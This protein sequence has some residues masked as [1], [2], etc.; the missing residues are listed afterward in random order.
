MTNSSIKPTTAAQAIILKAVHDF[1]NPPKVNL[2]EQVVEAELN[3]VEAENRLNKLKAEIQPQIDA[4]AKRADRRTALEQQA[5]RELAEDGQISS[6]TSVALDALDKSDKQASIQR[7][8]DDAAIDAANQNLKLQQ[9]I[10]KRE[11]LRFYLH[12]KDGPAQKA[13]AELR[14]L[15][16]VLLYSFLNIF[17]IFNHARTKLGWDASNQPLPAWFGPAGVL[18]DQLQNIR[19]VEWPAQIRPS[20][21]A[22]NGK[23]PTAEKLLRD[24]VAML[25]D[26]EREKEAA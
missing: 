23:R 17:R 2:P 3:V 12:S 21:A 14:E 19:W 18:L 20:W 24:F 16:E 15:F 1:K 13:I 9:S 10:Y 8:D 11:L 6:A 4:A 7:S 22:Q 25:A 5:H 26:A